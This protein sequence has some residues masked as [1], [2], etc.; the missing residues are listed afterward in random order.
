MLLIVPTGEF[1]YDSLPLLRERLEVERRK[2]L[3]RLENEVL[4]DGKAGVR[5]LT[6]VVTLNV[7]G[8]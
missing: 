5:I 4:R 8:L 2:E 3:R 7:E 1:V 6:S